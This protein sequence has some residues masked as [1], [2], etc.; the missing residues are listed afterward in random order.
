MALSFESDANKAKANFAKHEI[1]FEEASPVFGDPRWLTIPEPIHSAVEDRLSLSALR[2]VGNCLLS[3][4]PNENIRI[5]S[6][7]LASRGE[8]RSYEEST[9]EEQRYAARI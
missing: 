7:R 3:C 2:I 8:R 4:V 1:S 9:C 5:I 6:V